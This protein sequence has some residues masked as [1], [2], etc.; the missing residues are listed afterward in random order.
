MSEKTPVKRAPVTKVKGTSYRVKVGKLR[1][2]TT[3][4]QRLQHGAKSLVLDQLEKMALLGELD[5]TRLIKDTFAL[6]ILMGGTLIGSGIC[7]KTD[8]QSEFQR[9]LRS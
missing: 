1:P 7:W 5:L 8:P 3:P 9:W 2:S 4:D 6:A